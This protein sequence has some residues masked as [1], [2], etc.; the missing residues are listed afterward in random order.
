MQSF[1]FTG[2]QVDAESGLVFLRA[3]YYDPMTGRFVSKDPFGGF[4]NDTQSLNR[5]VYVQNNPISMAD[6]TGEIANFIIGGVVGG[7]VGFGAYTAVT[8]GTGAD[9]SWGK[10]AV[11]TGGGAV[12]GAALPLVAAGIA[13]GAIAPGALG[14]ALGVKGSVALV[15][16]ELGFAVGVNKSILNQQ[17]DGRP[18]D[19]SKT[20][21]D[22]GIDAVFGAWSGYSAGSSALSAF[23]K[24]KL[25]SG[26]WSYAYDKSNLRGDMWSKFWKGMLKANL[27]QHLDPK[28][29]YAPT[30]G[31]PIWY[32][33]QSSGGIFTALGLPPGVQK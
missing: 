25:A 27:Q 10:A 32:F 12:M 5:Y 14:T 22:G 29:V 21:T 30:F 20:M 6:P 11:A 28:V 19:W 16:A 18:I 8:L 4:D 3:R 2:E 17:I 24:G 9:W 33:Q 26:G 23:D 1:T 31:Y 7:V 15:G 13:S